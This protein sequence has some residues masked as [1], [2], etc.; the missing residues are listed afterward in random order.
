M[1][2][3]QH[4]CVGYKAEV[5]FDESR[6]ECPLYSEQIENYNLL[7][8]LESLR[9]WIGEDMYTRWEASYGKS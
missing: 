8:K 1:V 3:C 2:K 7:C 5:E 6:S 9:K 4:D